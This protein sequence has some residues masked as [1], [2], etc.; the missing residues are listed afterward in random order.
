M[1]AQTKGGITLA[2][3]TS[4]RK[5]PVTATNVAALVEAEAWTIYRARYIKEPGFAGI[6]DDALRALVIDSGANHGPAGAGTWLQEAV[7]DLAG[8]PLLKVDGAV[9]RTVF[10]DYQP[11]MTIRSRHSGKGSLE[12]DSSGERAD[13]EENR[14]SR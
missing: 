5:R 7:N 6:T 12:R 11:T 4:W 14:K 10:A 1:A 8:R 3:L 9:G 13:H 2:T